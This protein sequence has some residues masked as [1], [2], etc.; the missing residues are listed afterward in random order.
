MPRL[1]AIRAFN[2]FYFSLMAI[3]IS[4]LP[5]YMDA[6]GASPSEIGW[7]MGTGGIIGIIAQPIW[8]VISDRLKTIKRIILLLLILSMTIGYVLFQVES[9]LY[10]LLFTGFMYM[11]LMPIDPLIE[12]LNFQTAEH[13]KISYGSI[14]TFGAIGYALTSLIAGY[15]MHYFGANSLAA[16]FVIMGGIALI[17]SIYLLDAPVSSKPVTLTSLRAFFSYRETI[18]FFIL[19]FLTALP[20]RMNDNFLGVYIKSLGGTD[21]IVGL[22]WFL[23]GASE[24]IIFALSFWWLRKKRELLLITIASVFYML[25]FMASVWIDDPRYMAYLQV[26]HSVT[27]PVFYA[28]SISY[29]YR[30]VPEEW[31]ATGQTVLAIVFFGISGIAASFLGGWVFERYGGDQLYVVM[32]I[33]SAAALLLGLSLRKIIKS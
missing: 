1:F 16:L 24:T 28:A 17:A 2:Y 3:F 23:S 19:V 18:W 13:L 5:T 15:T 32:S 27:F 26:L 30:I 9:F 21:D 7:V 4:F 14:R 22:A 12:S 11:F 20:Q 8:G 6:Q 10:L 33:I 25:R 31:R 29:L